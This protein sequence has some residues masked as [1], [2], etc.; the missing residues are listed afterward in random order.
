MS[1]Q[2]N[3]HNDRNWTDLIHRCR[4]Y[5]PP[6]LFNLNPPHTS[7]C[8]FVHVFTALKLFTLDPPPSQLNHLTPI[9]IPHP[10]KWTTQLQ[11]QL[12]TVTDR[13]T[14]RDVQEGT[15]PNQCESRYISSPSIDSLMIS[16]SPATVG[17][18]TLAPDDSDVSLAPPVDGTTAGSSTDTDMSTDPGITIGTPPLLH[19]DDPNTG[20]ITDTNHSTHTDTTLPARDAVH[21]PLLEFDCKTPYP[22]VLY[23]RRWDSTDLHPFPL[24]E[25]PLTPPEDITFP[26]IYQRARQHEVVHN[27]LVNEYIIIPPAT[28]VT[29]WS[30]QFFLA[31]IAGARLRT[32]AHNYHEAQ[33]HRHIANRIRLKTVTC[34]EMFLNQSSILLQ[35]VPLPSGFVD[36]LHGPYHSL[37]QKCDQ[38]EHLCSKVAD[39][40]LDIVHTQNDIQIVLDS[41]VRPVNRYPVEDHHP[42]GIIRSWL[43]TTGLPLIHPSVEF[44]EALLGMPEC[45]FFALRCLRECGPGGHNIYEAIPIPL[46]VTS[47][48]CLYGHTHTDCTHLWLYFVAL[49]DQIITLKNTMM[50]RIGVFKACETLL[51]RNCDDIQTVL[52]SAMHADSNAKLVG[53]A[54]EHIF[55]ES[56]GEKIAAD[57]PRSSPTSRWPL[58]DVSSS[59]AKMVMRRLRDCL[60]EEQATSEYHGM[61]AHAISYNILPLDI[62]LQRIREYLAILSDHSLARPLTIAKED[63][64]LITLRNLTQSLP[65]CHH[66]V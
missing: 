23:I 25:I 48:A 5:S 8:T 62:A 18:A 28:P 38:I 44:T 11:Q 56:S 29:V 46:R 7:Q 24:D 22:P 17:T 49:H 39:R 10:Q 35:Q 32:A 65:A 50:A 13:T 57:L 47:T 27:C 2:H 58:P 6:Q 31:G 60:P 15:P 1:I 40:A 45:Y 64:D 63:P 41:W 4:V 30:L 61:K 53:D 52:S 9:P 26:N 59:L 3:Y 66:N 33:I 20:H 36:S 55:N 43:K 16:H 21:E 34:M 14:I 54:T 42:E 12:I 51:D 19:T 37:L